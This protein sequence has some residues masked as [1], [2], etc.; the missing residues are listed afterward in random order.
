M[1]GK[2]EIPFQSLAF[3]DEASTSFEKPKIS[4]KTFLI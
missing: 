3:L 2:S 1:I 4:K